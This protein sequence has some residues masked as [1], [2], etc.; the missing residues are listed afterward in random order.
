MIK[1]YKPILAL[2]ETINTVNDKIVGE[3]C[4]NARIAE[5]TDTHS[6]NNLDMAERFAA[7]EQSRLQDL[8]EQVGRKKR[9]SPQKYKK[10]YAAIYDNLESKRISIQKMLASEIKKKGRSARCATTC[11]TA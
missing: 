1:L 9:L 11:N 6:K 2:C 5:D 7:I 3:L 10:D 4:I 8:K